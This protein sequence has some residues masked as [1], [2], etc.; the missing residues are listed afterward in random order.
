MGNIIIPVDERMYST[1]KITSS[2]FPF[3]LSHDDLSCFAQG[4]VNWHRQTEIEISYILEGSARVCLL[5]EEHLLRAGDSFIVLPH[6]LHSIQPVPGEPCRYFT[7]IFSPSLLTGFPGSFFEQAWYTPFVTTVKG[8]HRLSGTPVS[9]A[10]HD[11]LFWIYAHDQDAEQETCLSIQRR[12]QDIWL[13]LVRHVF[14]A[15]PSA[16]PEDEDSRI[17]QMIDDLRAHYSEKFSLTAMAE[18]LH[19]SRGECCRYFKRMMGM[20]LT[21]YLNDY[22]LSKAAERLVLTQTSMSEIA[23]ATGFCSASHFSAEFRKKTGCTPSEYRAAARR[24]KV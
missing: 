18:R 22:R 16:A 17:L 3:F 7:L 19:V 11:H 10:I 8:Y 9:G 21:D 14:S 15:A 6:A 24:S 23:L 4:F 13:L 2:A 5:K 1:L 20:T 12:L